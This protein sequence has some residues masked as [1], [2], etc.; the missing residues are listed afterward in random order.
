MAG[1]KSKSAAGRNV[2]R[3]LHVRVRSVAGNGISFVRGWDGAHRC[4]GSLLEHAISVF[5][6]GWGQHVVAYQ[7]QFNDTT[8]R[9][10][11]GQSRIKWRLIGDLN[12]DKWALPPKP[13]WMR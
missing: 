2:Y 5:D 1:S 8:G 4:C 9:A 7:T 10:H 11:L 12:P 6:R 13:K 3:S